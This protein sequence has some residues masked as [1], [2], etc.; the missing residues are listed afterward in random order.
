MLRILEIF[1]QIK[2]YVCMYRRL[3]KIR[4]LDLT[5]DSQPVTRAAVSVTELF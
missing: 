3:C 4:I 5:Y 1:E 2:M